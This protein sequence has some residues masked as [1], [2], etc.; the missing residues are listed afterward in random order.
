MCVSLGRVVGLQNELLFSL[1]DTTFGSPNVGQNVFRACDTV[2]V[3]EI[4]RLAGKSVEESCFPLSAK[5]AFSRTGRRCPTFEHLVE[6]R[7]IV[8]DVVERVLS[9]PT[10]MR[11]YV[12]EVLRGYLVARSYRI[13]QSAEER[14]LMIGCSRGLVSAST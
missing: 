11:L 6:C 10:S 9:Y 5:F 8:L 2:R 12:S 7:R 1:L 4:E 3:H 14:S 13:M